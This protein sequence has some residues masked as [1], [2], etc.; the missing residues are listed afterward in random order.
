VAAADSSPQIAARV[1]QFQT[2]E[3]LMFFDLTADPSERHNLIVTL[4]LPNGFGTWESVC[5]ST[6]SRL[7]ILRPMLSAR[8]LLR[9][10]GNIERLLL[11]RP[12]LFVCPKSC[13]L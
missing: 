8:L 4:P 5:C 9:G 10:V 3:P 6:W 2:G 1:R 7:R 12:P 11:P 13:A